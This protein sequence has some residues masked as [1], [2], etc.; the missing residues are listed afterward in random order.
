MSNSTCGYKAPLYN[1]SNPL[2]SDRTD[3]ML[4]FKAPIFAS[5]DQFN[6]AN[7]YQGF[8]LWYQL[9]EL[10]LYNYFIIAQRSSPIYLNVFYLK[11]N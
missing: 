6:D 9:G 5:I 1:E 4:L 10:L 3:V 11:V 2:V 7:L 8:Q